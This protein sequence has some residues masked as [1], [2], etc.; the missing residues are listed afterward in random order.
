MHQVERRQSSRLIAVLVAAWVGLGARPAGA[1]W[2]TVQQVTLGTAQVLEP[3]ALTFGVLSPIAYGVSERLTIESHPILDLLLVP[4]LAARYRVVERRTAVASVT[5]AYKQSFY[6]QSV[7]QPVSPGELDVGM[8][9]TWYVTSRLALSAAPAFSMRMAS[10][11]KA[12]SP[13]FGPAAS[14]QL[15]Y[16]LGD[17]DLL[18]ASAL[19]RVDLTLGQRD[20]VTGTFAWVHG[21]NTVHLVAGMSWGRFDFQPFMF[22]RGAHTWPVMPLLD[23]WWRY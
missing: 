5:A 1:D 15:H 20:P 21:W 14:V 4:N 3:G 17:R 8:I 22:V 12:E 11:P 13:T 16:L 6:G 2:K 10:D 23:L 18:M 19:E 9:G 7:G